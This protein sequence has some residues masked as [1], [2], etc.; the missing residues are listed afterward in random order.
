MGF[1]SGRSAVAESLSRTRDDLR[2]PLARGH[3]DV[4]R[5][6]GLNEVGYSPSRAQ[7]Y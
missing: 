2:M 7:S 6:D 1:H 4:T 5:T 3:G